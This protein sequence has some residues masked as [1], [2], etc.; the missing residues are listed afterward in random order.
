MQTWVPWPILV[1]PHPVVEPLTP[2]WERLPIEVLALPVVL[3]FCDTYPIAVLRDPKFRSRA[4]D[5]AAV[6]SSVVALLA[7]AFSPIAVF[8]KPVVFALKARVPIAVL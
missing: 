2:Y 1:L 8:L 6:L 3:F 5:P 7:R 4:P